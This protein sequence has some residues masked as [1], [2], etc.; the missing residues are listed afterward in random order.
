MERV[1][2]YLGPYRCDPQVSYN[3][4]H[5]IT[6]TPQV[7]TSVIPIPENQEITQ[8]QSPIFYGSQIQEA[9]IGSSEDP[10]TPIPIRMESTFD[11]YPQDLQIVPSF[12]SLQDVSTSSYTDSGYDLQLYRPLPHTTN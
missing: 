9:D 6:E 5:A 8:V 3:I 4:G 1:S 10:L 12:E 11:D 7:Q 2:I